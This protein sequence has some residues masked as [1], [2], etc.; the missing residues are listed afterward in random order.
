MASEGC[1]D[2]VRELLPR[3]DTDAD[4]AHSFRDLHEIQSVVKYGR[5]ISLAVEQVL[6]LTHHAEDAV[7][8]NDFD[9][10]DAVSDR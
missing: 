1:A 3:R 8:H 4:R 9:H 5:G 10:L 2:G 7:V 6:P